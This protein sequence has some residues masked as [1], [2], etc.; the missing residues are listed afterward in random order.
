[1]ALAENELA[2]ADEVSKFLA[3]H[4]LLDVLELFQEQWADYATRSSVPV[5]S[6]DH[7]TDAVASVTAAT[8]VTAISQTPLKESGKPVVVA[9]SKKYGITTVLGDETDLWDCDD[10]NEVS[11]SYPN[12]GGLSL[13]EFEEAKKSA[14]SMVPYHPY[15]KVAPPTNLP[16]ES[17][18]LRII[19]EAGRTGFEEVKEFPIVVNS[20]IAGRYQVL[21]F[22]DSAAFSRAVKCLD[23]KHGHEVCVKVIR[24]SKDFYDQA[25]DEIKLLQYINCGGDPDENCVLQLFDYFYYKEHVFIVTELLRDNLYEFGKFNREQE[26]EPYFTLPR[27][28]S[29]ARQVLKAL[30][31]L[32]KLNLLHCDLKPENILVKSYSR[33]EIKVID[34]GSSC[35]TSDNLSSY[36]QSRCYRAPEVIL[37]CHYNGGIDVWSLGAIL[38]ELMTGNVMFHNETVPGMLARIAGVCG[39]YP[40]RMLHEGRHTCRFVSQ[41]GAFYEVKKETDQLVFHF[42]NVAPLRSTNLGSDDELYI[43]FVEKCLTVDH[44]LRP[45]AAELLEHPFLKKDYGNVFSSPPALKA[46]VAA[47]PK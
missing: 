34:F 36:I 8:A 29:I 31:Y 26:T 16:L 24:N 5:M 17:F 38:P 21:Q 7:T 27:V 14:T 25:L 43:N 10:L 2:M 46:A 40:A 28:Q 41:H 47:S 22:L 19:Y 11:P 6:D 45:S 4:H 18:D 23:L 9:S 33:C 15:Q 35:F 42:P 32:H 13:V 12:G 20:V 37:G 44:T 39:P 1:M 3:K 30:S